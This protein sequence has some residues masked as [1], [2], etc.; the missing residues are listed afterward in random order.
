MRDKS[1]AKQNDFILIKGFTYP[2]PGQE[3]AIILCRGNGYGTVTVSTL[4]ALAP[5][6][7]YAEAVKLADALAA[8]KKVNFGKTFSENDWL[9]FER[10]SP[11]WKEWHGKQEVKERAGI[12]PAKEVVPVGSAEAGSPAASGQAA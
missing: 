12:F 3:K 6:A 9:G 7:T 8:E 2:F 5:S 11:E 4:T 1:S 10:D